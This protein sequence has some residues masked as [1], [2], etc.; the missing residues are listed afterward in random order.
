MD[1]IKVEL[2]IVQS[3][4]RKVGVEVPIDVIA[5]WSIRDRSKIEQWAIHKRWS[6]MK[7]PPCPPDHAGI[8]AVLVRPR[9]LN[10]WVLN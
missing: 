4:L 3:E 8:R 9:L 7:R 5:K 6:Q 10:R 2:E 1:P